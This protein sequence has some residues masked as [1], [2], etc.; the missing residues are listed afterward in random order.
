MLTREQ[1]FEG[2]SPLAQRT[3]DLSVGAVAISQADVLQD[4]YLPGYAFEIVSIQHFAGALDAAASYDL[5]IGTTSALTAAEVPVAATRE[6]A[7][8]NATLANLK[9]GA[10]DAINLH[11]TTDG[12]GTFTGLKVRVTIRPQGTR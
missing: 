11:A 6:D 8:L 1:H 9:G 2:D 4:S 12:S 7:V 10:T 3:I 5:K